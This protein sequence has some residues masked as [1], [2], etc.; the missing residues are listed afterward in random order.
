[1]RH[2]NSQQEATKRNKIQNNL[3]TLCLANVSP[4]LPILPQFVVDTLL[5]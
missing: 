1:M 3:R 4:S 5:S 2:D